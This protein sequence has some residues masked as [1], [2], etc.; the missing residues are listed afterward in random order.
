MFWRSL[1]T[2]KHYAYLK[3]AEG[4]DN[5]CSFCSIPF[6]RGL[7]KSRPIPNIREEA[8][9]L[10]NQGVRELLIIAQDST[11]YGWDLPEKVYLSDLL[12]ELDNLANEMPD[13]ILKWIRVHYAHPA[14]LSQRIIDAL[15]SSS[16][17]A[18]YLDM[19][20]QHANNRI[21]DS[22][23]RGLGRDGIRNRITRLRTAIPDIRLRTT[24]IVGYPGETDEEFREL[25]NF[26]EEIEFDR[27]GVFPYSEEEGTAAAGLT[28][29]IPREVKDERK[30]VLLDLQNEISA[31]KNSELVG[32]TL[33][34]LIDEQGNSVSVGRTEFDSPEVDNIVRVNGSV[35]PGEFIDVKIEDYNAYEL[36]GRPVSVLESIC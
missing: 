6:M 4:C 34:V 7:Q 29:D 22:M 24:L 10:G 30:A 35:T 25:Y 3:I 26:M 13:D 19:P 5:G 31:R 23:N 32:N 8:E 1:L 36:I 33:K 15:A 9:R 27:I 20:I 18:R 21:L 12:Q 28:D 14:H 16:H 11:S 2:P 17:L